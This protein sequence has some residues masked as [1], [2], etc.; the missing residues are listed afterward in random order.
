MRGFL[1]FAFLCAVGV[2]GALQLGAVRSARNPLSRSTCGSRSSLKGVFGSDSGPDLSHYGKKLFTASTAGPFLKKAGLSK[3]ALSSGEWVKSQDGADRMAIAL[4][5]WAKAEG[6]TS[7]THWWQPQASTDVRTGMTAQ[8][9]NKMLKF[10]K[11]G[12]IEWSLDGDRLIQGETDGSSFPNGG[13]RATHTAG[14]YLTPD[15]S[16]PPFIRDDVMYIPSVLITY[17]G[18]AL[19]E[20]LPL[21]RSADALKREGARLMKHLG[22]DTDTVFAQIG[23]EQE[24]FM[25]PRQHFLD[26]PDLLHTGRTVMGKFAPR[27]QE[28][29]D[30]YMAPLATNS[31]FVDA[32]AKVQEKCF[33]MGIPL[34]TRHKEVAPGQFEFAPMFGSMTTQIDQNLLVMQIIEEVAKDYGLAALFTEK[35]FD[36]VNGSGK[37]NNWSI[38]TGDGTNL[39]NP[40]QILAKTGSTDVFA[41]VMAAMLTAVDEHGDLMRLSISCPGNDFRLGA[42]EAPPAIMS[43]YLGEE[44]TSYLQAFANGGSAAQ[45]NTVLKEMD[46]GASALAK[47]KKP[48]GDRNRSS[49]FPYGGNRFEFRAVGSSQNVSIVNMVLAAIVANSF[50]MFSEQIEAGKDPKAVA[51]E[52]LKKHMKVIFN[53][54]GYD[55][56]EQERLTKEGYTRIDSGVEAMSKFTDAKNVKLFSDL[57]ILAPHEVTARQAVMFEH[58][59]GMVEMEA[60]SMVQMI[61][62][63]VVPSVENAKDV[64]KTTGATEPRLDAANLK[65]AAQEINDAIAGIH[66]AANAEEGARLARVLRLEQMV[67]VRKMC[68][69]AEAVCPKEVWTLPSYADMLFDNEW[70]EQ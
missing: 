5:E 33:E 6:A 69:E 65:K 2:C 45:F 7:M 68:D 64:L 38:A 58:Y 30:H 25:I 70:L 39:L 34:A 59:T 47:I 27:G 26:R 44:I 50:K 55:P 29:S 32:M 22:L 12:E 11:D 28:M 3:E 8:L 15:P 51:Q 18:D 46:T 43:M 24:I 17:N 35:P 16:S 14:A 60:L 21:L 49:P 48:S 36:G 54:N 40:K 61:E 23:L 57:G 42:C 20:K 67:E 66:A 10:S 31:V 41:I 62:Q 9:Y 1:I 56:A 19:D 13:L 52:A 37:H 53:G 4:M 63:H